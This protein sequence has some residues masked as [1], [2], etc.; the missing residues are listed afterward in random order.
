M[1][2]VTYQKMA[3]DVFYHLE[4]LKTDLARIK[5]NWNTD[6]HLAF[7]INKCNDSC[8]IIENLIRRYDNHN[9]RKLTGLINEVLINNSELHGVNVLVKKEQKLPNFDY[10][11][12]ALI[13]FTI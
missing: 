2:E 6:S 9:F 3:V 5:L 13:V 8:E 1:S 4:L 11:K 10:S 12:V 7:A